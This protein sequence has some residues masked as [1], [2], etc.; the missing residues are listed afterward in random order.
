MSQGHIPDHLEPAV[1]AILQDWV[2]AVGVDGAWARLLAIVKGDEK[3]ARE[4]VEELFPST[5]PV[6]APVEP[7]A[8]SPSPTA[9]PVPSGDWS[10]H[11]ERQ[12]TFYDAPAYYWWMIPDSQVRP[13]LMMIRD[14][15][16]TGPEMELCGADP[17]NEY[18]NR[19]A[20]SGYDILSWYR[21]AFARFAIWNPI[22]A[23]LGM[24]A[25]IKFTQANWSAPAAQS[26]RT[27]SDQWAFNLAVEFM[28][29]FG[30]TN[31]IILDA[32]ETDSRFPESIRHA[33]R[34]GLIEG[35]MP[36]SQLVGYT[37]KGDLGFVENHPANFEKIVSGDHT[38]LQIPD[39][40]SMIELLY[41]SNWRQGGSPNTGNIQKYITLCRRAGTS[42]GTYS[43]RRDPDTLGLNAVRQVL[44]S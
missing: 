27:G 23:E 4:I 38:R 9:A 31:K 11:L 35:G 43:F 26:K 13:W 19:R 24:V 34:S 6:P 7:P 37:N 25:N 17:V 18:I 29:T 5:M 2:N 10:R 44:L 40:G 32:N 12:M 39:N 14:A 28:R 41:G 30:P 1:R 36:R 22:L 16:C 8:P 3:L 33:I 21:T 42:T 15:G 20:T